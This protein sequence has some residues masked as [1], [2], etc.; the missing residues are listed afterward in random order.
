MNV[1]SEKVAPNEEASLGS[2]RGVRKLPE[3]ALADC[4]VYATRQDLF[5][6][7]KISGN[8]ACIFAGD[9]LL[10]EELRAGPGNAIIHVEG[11]AA[12]RG[13]FDQLKLGG[14]SQLRFYDS[15]KAF[16]EEHADTKFDLVA[17]D[18]GPTEHKY[19]RRILRWAG[20]HVHP[21]S[22]CILIRRYS[23]WLKGQR[24]NEMVLAIN[25]FVINSGSKL[26]ALVLN[27]DGRPDVLIRLGEAQ[28]WSL[29]LRL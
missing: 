15:Y 25:N 17:I 23:F 7:H 22:G 8:V 20:E 21:K 28:N 12:R 6:A 19:A 26:E 29:A 3:E 2:A 5:K 18:R 16:S 13:Q 9:V 1:S 24:V 14:T 4:K 10:A 11:R 27:G